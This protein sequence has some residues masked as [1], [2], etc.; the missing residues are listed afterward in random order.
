MIPAR[1]PGANPVRHAGGELGRGQ[2]LHRGHPDRA[3][4]LGV[5]LGHQR[6]QDPGAAL[7]PAAGLLRGPAEAG[8]GHD[9][10]DERLGAH[11]T[12]GQRRLELV[13]DDPGHG[14]C[15]ACGGAG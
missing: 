3:A 11:A 5:A 10:G 6:V 12:P 9:E 4:Q 1:S 15:V 7:E 14:G 8:L 13:V 2:P